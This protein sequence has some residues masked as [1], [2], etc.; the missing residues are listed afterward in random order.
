MTDKQIAERFLTKL[1]EAPDPDHRNYVREDGLIDGWFEPKDI[2]AAV[3]HALNPEV[4]DMAARM[5]AEAKRQR[6]RWAIG[7]LL[8]GAFLS[9]IHI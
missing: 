8:L 2:A 9:L 1:G 3:L 5:L 4:S 6:E 7:A